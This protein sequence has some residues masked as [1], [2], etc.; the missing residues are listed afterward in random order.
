MKPISFWM[1]SSVVNF[2]TDNFCLALK[3]TEFLILIHYWYVSTVC[4]KIAH[5]Q[6]DLKGN[7]NTFTFFDNYFDDYVRGNQVHYI[8]LESWPVLW[9]AK[10]NAFIV[11]LQRCIIQSK[12]KSIAGVIFLSVTQPLVNFRKKFLPYVPLLVLLV[13]MIPILSLYDV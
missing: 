6:Q 1:I 4:Q 2:R 11:S 7:W 13:L 5:F 8:E 3:K 10:Y 12:W 9:T